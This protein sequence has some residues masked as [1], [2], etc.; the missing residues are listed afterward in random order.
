MKRNIIVFTLMASVLWY[1]IGLLIV[2]V[3]APD[4]LYPTTY[5]RGM[6]LLL[7][8]LAGTPF[9]FLI[10]L[11]PAIAAGTLISAWTREASPLAF[12]KVLTVAIGI[13][14][15]VTMI[16]FLPLSSDPGSGGVLVFVFLFLCSLLT[17][18]LSWLIVQGLKHPL[19]RVDRSGAHS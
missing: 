7:A 1:W 4:I 14:L 2:A 11:C 19:A 6:P 17:I 13:S 12:L 16:A 15:D 18:T 5:F 3:C 8:F 9:A 10:G